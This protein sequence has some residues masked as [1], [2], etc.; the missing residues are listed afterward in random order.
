MLG[1]AVRDVLGSEGAKV[2]KEDKQ[3]HFLL[4]VFFFPLE[5]SVLTAV[6]QLLLSK[7]TF[8]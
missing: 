1:P 3:T 2:R 7:S 8:P 6:W 5:P 4:L